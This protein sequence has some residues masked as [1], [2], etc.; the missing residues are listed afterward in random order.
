M[1][2]MKLND[3]AL[4]YACCPH[5]KNILIRANTITYGNIICSKCSKVV[6][7]EIQNG[8]VITQIEE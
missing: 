5:C 3:K 6:H 7:V 4:S 1:S 8:K 2:E